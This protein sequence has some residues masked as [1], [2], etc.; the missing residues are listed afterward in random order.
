MI[1]RLLKEDINILIKKKSAWFALLLFLLI[2]GANIMFIRSEQP[3]ANPYFEPPSAFEYFVSVQGGGSGFLLLFL[4]LAVTLATGDIFIRERRSSML[5]Y[6]I[7][8]ANTKQYIQSRT[9]S[10]GIASFLFTFISQLLLFLGT[11]LFFPITQ[12]STD[13]GIVYYAA[14][15]FIN[16]PWI[17]CFIIIVNSALMAFSFSCLSVIISIIF[18][19]LYVSIMLPYVV[20]IGF[21]EILMSLPMFLGFQGTLFYNLSPLS[22]AGDY[23]TKSFHW[24][25]VPIYWIF[26]SIISVRIAII[27]FKNRFEKEKLL[28]R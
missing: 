5:S 3:I 21:S 16:N 12:P 9:V 26:I 27:L 2:A 4:P 28:L 18:Q 25:T 7:V 14:N 11:L 19:N 17:Y 13:Q 23:I 22:M 15:I 20:F 1:L 8:R 10:L 6:S 24:I